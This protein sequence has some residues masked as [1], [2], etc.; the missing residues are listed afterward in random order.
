MM[1]LLRVLD[2]D[3]AKDGIQEAEIDFEVEE[4]EGEES[5]DSSVS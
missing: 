1:D 2:V 5:K 3:A 4:V